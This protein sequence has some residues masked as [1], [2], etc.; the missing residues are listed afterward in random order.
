MS[1][2]IA[3]VIETVVQDGIVF[4]Y[5]NKNEKTITKTDFENELANLQVK[6]T[7]VH[8]EIAVMQGYIDSIDAG[9]FNEFV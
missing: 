1:E 7:K 8:A 9:K 5:P 2:E 3:E 4:L 6:D